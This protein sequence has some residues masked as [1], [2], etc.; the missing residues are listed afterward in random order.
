MDHLPT[1][2]PVTPEIVEPSRVV[3]AELVGFEMPPPLWRRVLA[4][5]AL[6]VILGAIGLVL[7]VV[8][9]I[10]TV[11]I[12]GAAIGVPLILLGLLICAF[13][14]FAPFARGPGRFRVVTW[15]R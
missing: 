13:A 15:P 5:A 3:D 2:T 4:R 8:G 6:A 11:T 12:I 14:L 9:V 10:L 7:V 1:Q